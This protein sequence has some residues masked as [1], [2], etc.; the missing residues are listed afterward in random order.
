MKSFKMKKESTS[1]Q[2]V[3]PLLAVLRHNNEMHLFDEIWEQTKHTETKPQAIL[4]AK[5]QAA[6]GGVAVP[7]PP[8]PMPDTMTT[9]SFKKAI[10]NSDSGQRYGRKPYGMTEPR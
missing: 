1:R 3:V 9:E 8:F 2:V 10:I 6:S 7:P 5:E 4:A